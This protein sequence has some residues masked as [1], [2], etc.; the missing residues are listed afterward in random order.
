M[1]EKPDGCQRDLTLSSKEEKNESPAR[2]DPSLTASQHEGEGVMRGEIHIPHG[3]TMGSYGVMRRAKKDSIPSPEKP[4]RARAK[5]SA[6]NNKHVQ[7]TH[8]VDSHNGIGLPHERHLENSIHANGYEEYPAERF[9]ADGRYVST[10]HAEGP[11]SS[12]FWSSEG[13]SWG[14]ASPNAAV[15]KHM[16]NQYN[17]NRWRS[18]ESGKDKTKPTGDSDT[19][20]SS[21]APSEA[22]RVVPLKPE[23]SKKLKGNKG[24]SPQD[25][26]DRSVIDTEEEKTNQESSAFSAQR[27][28]R[29][30][31]GETAAVARRDPTPK[32]SNREARAHNQTPWLFQHPADS[33]NQRFSA[34]D[35]Q[36]YCED[37][38]PLS[39]FPSA[40]TF[41]GFDHVNPLCPLVKSQRTRDTRSKQ[42]AFI[43]SSLCLLKSS[44]LD[45]TKRK[46]VVTTAWHLLVT[47]RSYRHRMNPPIHI[48]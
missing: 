33:I 29:V 18:S 35:D 30:G 17:G 19:L 13:R 32:G 31:V 8:S 16:R 1:I 20:K 23:R 2:I 36:A 38:S 47:H 22:K 48:L 11:A 15:D 24:V 14:E 28:G 45:S 40:V 37:P 6:L 46:P 5:S 26:T 21:A 3:G 10:S 44:S 39:D 9:W 4:Q 41:S 25:H 34:G 27:S 7:D 12:D 43:D 42:T